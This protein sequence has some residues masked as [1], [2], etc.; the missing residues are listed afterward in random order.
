MEPEE[1]KKWLKRRAAEESTVGVFAGCVS[2]IGGALAWIAAAAVVTLVLLVGF[3]QL[4]YLLNQAFG[5]SWAVGMSASR[6]LS[7]AAVV[8]LGLLVLHGQVGKRHRAELTSVRFFVLDLVCSGPRFVLDGIG[9]F[10]RV[11]A[12]RELDL[13]VCARALSVLLGSPRRVPLDELERSVIGFR[14]DK[15]IDQLLL[16]EG[17]VLLRRPQAGMSLTSDLRAALTGKKQ[18]EQESRGNSQTRRVVFVCQGCGRS[19][20]V[21]WLLIGMNFRCPQCDTEHRTFQ[22]AQGRIRVEKQAPKAKRPPVRIEIPNDP[23]RT[24]GLPPDAPLADVK[25]AYRRQMKEHH[26]DLVACA[27]E[28]ERRA[29]EEKSKE[30]NHAYRTILDAHRP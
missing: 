10:R 19:L 7:L 3:L 12:W 5:V 27:G 4:V 14:R 28:F 21:P 18:A 13:D 8:F 22:D 24:L 20:R 2:L 16:I 11:Q 15:F 23:Y 26:P 25:R 17:V 30:I 9:C 6:I 1:V 29:A